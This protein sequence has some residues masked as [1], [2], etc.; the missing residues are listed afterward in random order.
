MVHKFPVHTFVQNFKVQV[1]PPACTANLVPISRKTKPIRDIGMAKSTRSHTSNAL[2]V[3]ECNDRYDSSITTASAMTPHAPTTLV[4]SSSAPSPDEVYIPA[5]V[6][7]TTNQDEPAVTPNPRVLAF[8]QI[9]LLQKS[10]QNLPK[11]NWRNPLVRNLFAIRFM[12]KN[13]CDM[14]YYLY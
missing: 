3:P 13:V 7:T 1:Q 9:S 10:F 4:D 12:Q 6:G 14:F 5:P 8:Q 2:L 11:F